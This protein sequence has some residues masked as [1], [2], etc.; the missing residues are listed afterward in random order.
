MSQSSALTLYVNPG[1]GLNGLK[2]FQNG[3]KKTQAHVLGLTSSIVGITAKVALMTLGFVGFTSAIGGL[4]LGVRAAKQ[5][6][7]ALSETLTLLEGTASETAFLKK[8]SEELVKV[9]GGNSAKMLEGFYQS[10]SAGM[11]DVAQSAEFMEVA[12]KLSVGGVADTTI[13]IDALSS[14]VNAYGKEVLSANK[15]SDI[16]F[17]TVRL[18]KTTVSELGSVIGRLTSLAAPFGIPFEQI[19]AAISVLTAQ[20]LNTPTTVTALGQTINA[21]VKPTQQALEKLEELSKKSGIELDF[22]A[23]TV[24]AK[25]FLG[26]M[27]DIYDAARGDKNVLGEI[28]PTVQA[29]RAV[30]PLLTNKWEKY[31]E[32]LEVFYTKSA[33][34][35]EEAFKKIEKSLSFRFDREISGIGAKF[36][37]L[38]R[39]ILHYLTPVLELINQSVDDAFGDTDVT[40]K[41]L[42]FLA[43]ASV[44]AAGL[45]DVIQPVISTTWEGVNTLKD[46]WDTLPIEFKTVGI[47]G[48]ILLGKKGAAA[49]LGTAWIMQKGIDLW[50]NY[51]NEIE[52]PRLPEANAPRPAPINEA[53]LRAQEEERE[54][55]AAF[56]KEY[57]RLNR[58]VDTLYELGRNAMPSYRTP[59]PSMYVDPVKE[60]K[61]AREKTQAMMDKMLAEYKATV[62][63]ED[64]K[65]VD[66]QVKAIIGDKLDPWPDGPD[67]GDTKALDRLKDSYDGLRRALDPAIDRQM[68]LAEGQKILK[69][70]FEAGFIV[71]KEG[72]KDMGEFT[73]LNQILID[74]ITGLSDR[75]ERAKQGFKEF[76]RPFLT[77]AKKAADLIDDLGNRIAD[78]LINSGLDA[79][80]DS[81]TGTLFGDAVGWLFG[82]A[83]GNI[84]QFG[85][86]VPFQYGGVVNKPTKFPMND[87]RTGIMSEREPEA[88]MPLRRGPDGRLGVESTGGGSINIHMGGINIDASGAD[89]AAVD[90]LTIEV[91]KLQTQ[92]PS[93]IVST[94]RKARKNRVL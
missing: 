26:I 30:L 77:G 41:F 80:F 83:K 8:R 81:L 73:R 89:P 21:M 72:V 2:A 70:A 53:L 55:K 45:Y 20:G 9:Y 23:A 61:S 22:S 35:T 49:V 39:S 85:N 65:S 6:S 64:Y 18:G 57:Q 11:G 91:N 7:A 37:L 50:K 14:V 76:W 87:G 25:G 42:E 94:V 1:P 47:F 75:M 74:Q 92:L 60:P 31:N 88:I 51:V 58:G 59:D 63:T 3:L 86:L 62:G 10:I 12:L 15:A 56:E 48:L 33:G 84:F 69:D 52:T 34:A 36:E 40:L 24:E 78:K 4:A 90:R 67:E 93:T 44:M 5:H 79:I 82:S 66:D 16:L 13:A 32:V 68:Q 28:F 19:S 43:S 71:T 46:F 17:T 29:L 27:K 38:G 54:A